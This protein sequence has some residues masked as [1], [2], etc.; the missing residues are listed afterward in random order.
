M[1]KCKKLCFLIL[2]SSLFLGA[3]NTGK[4]EDSSYHTEI[5][6][7]ES[8]E[9]NTEELS[10]ET[11]STPET[12]TFVDAW[13]EW[14]YDVPILSDAEKHN[15]NWDCLSNDGQT[16]SYTGDTNYTYRLGID[17]SKYQEYVNWEKVKA[18]GYEFVIIRLGFRGYGKEG[19]IHLDEK[20]HQHIKGAQ[21]AGLDVGVYFFSQAVNE[22]EALEE[23]QFVLDTLEG[24]DLQMPIVYDPELIRDA[25][26][27]T[28][29]VTGEQF[30][31]NAITFC[32]AIADAGYTP[33]IYSNMVWEAFLF[34]MTALENYDFWYADY[35][36]IPQTPYDF[37]MWQY[38][39]SGHVNGISGKVDLN[40]QFFP[41][42]EE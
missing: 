11:L 17:V 7:T 2:A 21:A 34:D 12:L 35:E 37:S 16:I 39:E 1:K 22:E 24:Y 25:S 40:I 28:D 33:M 10:T 38:T 5:I 18:D 14:Y 27:R 19:S 15:Y 6:L 20:F 23:A 42:N 29:N 8:S 30:T 31:K 13:G 26:A 36:K 32:E 41:T 4:T 9:E 3:C